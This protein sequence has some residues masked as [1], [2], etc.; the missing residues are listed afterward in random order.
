M[1]STSSGSACGRPA[2]LT[3]A[4]A[5]VEGIPKAVAQ[6]V[7]SYDRQDDED[8]GQEQPGGLRQVGQ[9]GSRRQQVP[10]GGAGFADAEADEAQPGLAQDR[11]GDRQ[12]SP[13]DDKRT[14][15]R[16]D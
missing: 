7:V 11:P 6:E 16:E 4:E 15:V 1:R 10:P 14:G 8:P 3:R 2:R 13:D 9:V 12:G 5:G